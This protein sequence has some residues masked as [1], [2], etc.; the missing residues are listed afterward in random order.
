MA[1]LKFMSEDAFGR[2]QITHPVGGVLAER[3]AH[4][5]L[6]LQFFHGSRGG[7]LPH[8]PVQDDPLRIGEDLHPAGALTPRPSRHFRNHSPG[9]PSPGPQQAPLAQQPPQIPSP[10]NRPMPT[11]ELPSPQLQ[12]RRR[13]SKPNTPF[14]RSP[15]KS[16]TL[17]PPGMQNPGASTKTHKSAGAAQ[18]WGGRSKSNFRKW[19]LD[20]C[21]GGAEMAHLEGV[22]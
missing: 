7:R 13:H 5:A 17:P 22:Q 15:P 4:A 2:Q 12:C 1:H 9:R 16:L 10:Q 3:I 14:A 18:D 20:C 19:W 6:E 21:P 11:P 8:Q